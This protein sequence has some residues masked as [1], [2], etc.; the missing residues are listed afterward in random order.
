MGKNSKA[1]DAQMKRAYQEARRREEAENQK[2]QNRI[3]R[4]SVI[5]AAAILLIVL[6][7]AI[8]AAVEN[9]VPEMSDLD[10]SS[11]ALADCTDTEQKTDY[12]RLNIT[13]TDKD[14]VEQ[15]GDVVIRLF[16]KV[17]PQ[18]VANFK[19]L[20]S[21]DFYDGLTFHRIYSG[22]MIQGG[23]PNGDG[24]GGNGDKTIKGEFTENGV[25]NNLSHVRGV[26]SMARGQ[27]NDSASSQFFI[28][29]QDSTKL[30]GSYAAFGYVVCGMDTVDGIAETEVSYS[31]SLNDSVPTLPKNPVTINYITFVT[32]K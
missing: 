22:F 28:V 9:R 2:R 14:G 18:T 25:T 21:K 17:A 32:V 31:T 23:D 11:V 12:V 3:T 8:I 16:E 7:V 1:Q 19:D 15:T 5:G 26:I 24:T 6:A 27:E 4:L 30:D 20:V 13:Y 10:F 29:H